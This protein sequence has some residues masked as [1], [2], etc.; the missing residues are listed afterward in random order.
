MRRQFTAQEITAAI[1][2]R[3]CA[4]AARSSDGVWAFYAIEGVC[5][6]KEKAEACALMRWCD[7]SESLMLDML[8]LTGKI[9]CIPISTPH[10]VLA[11]TKR[12][13]S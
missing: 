6:I 13:V 1:R 8:E 9:V 5:F 12:L 2:P 4:Y 10:G 11:I 7:D 3:S